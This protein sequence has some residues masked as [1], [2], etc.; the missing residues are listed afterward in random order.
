MFSSECGR[1]GLCKTIVRSG[2]KTTLGS[3]RRRLDGS[4]YDIGH[5]HLGLCEAVVRQC[6]VDLC[7]IQDAIAQG[8]PRLP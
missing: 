7:L 1:L 5:D 3:K 2:H 4:R 6:C 8:G